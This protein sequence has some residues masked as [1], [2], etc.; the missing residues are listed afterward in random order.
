MFYDL[1]HIWV[2]GAMTRFLDAQEI[3]GNN[4]RNWIE[5]GFIHLPACFL[6][7]ESLASGHA[8]AETRTDLAPLLAEGE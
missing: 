2:R 4:L 8:G 1:S 5:D 7:F 3:V 6:F